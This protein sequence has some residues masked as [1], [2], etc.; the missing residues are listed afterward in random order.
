MGRRPAYVP[1]WTPAEDGIG[2]ALLRIVAR[3]AEVAI[4]RLN[5]SPDKNRVAFL[6]T[7]GISLIPAQPARAVVVFQPL[8][9]GVDSRIAA[10]T[11]VG[12]QV[13]GQLEPI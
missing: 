10:G 6:D 7:L 9:L 2:Q 1:E 3:Y 12:A 4:A 5:Q 8:P 13:A 11:Q